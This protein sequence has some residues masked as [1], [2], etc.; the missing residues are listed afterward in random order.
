MQSGIGVKI[1]LMNNSH[2]GMVRQWQHLFFSERY[3]ETPMTNPDF[4]QIAAAYRIP[5]RR[6]SVREELDAAIAEMLNAPGAYLLEVTVEQKGLV[7]PM[8]PAGGGL[9][10]MLLGD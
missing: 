9:D 5:G 1:I 10:E 8:I 4:V 6:V 2:L 3:S 7:Y